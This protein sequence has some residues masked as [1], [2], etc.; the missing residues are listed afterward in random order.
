MPLIQM[1]L[2]QTAILIPTSNVQANYTK[3]TSI[4]GMGFW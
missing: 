1:K 2:N 4:V 3:A